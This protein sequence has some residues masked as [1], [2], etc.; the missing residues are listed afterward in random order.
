MGGRKRIEKET[1][2]ESSLTKTYWANVIRIK[3]R[4]ICAS[5]PLKWKGK[6]HGRNF[7]YPIEPGKRKALYKRKNKKKEKRGKRGNRRQRR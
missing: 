3:G 6:R 7:E 5:L 4:S 2:Q 1:E